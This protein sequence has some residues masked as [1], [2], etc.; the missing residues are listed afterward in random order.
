MASSD[1]AENLGTSAKLRLR[2]GG[3]APIG[4]MLAAVLLTGCGGHSHR[5]A[6]A[7]P[8]GLFDAQNQTTLSCLAHQKQPPGPLYTGG[9][10][11]DTAHILQMMQYYTSNG[12]KP[13]CDK[14]KPSAIDLDWARLY[15]SLGGSPAKVPA[16]LDAP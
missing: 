2:A 5:T 13:F 7:T 1:S 3:R 6:S 16:V 10:H 14:A 11:A 4:A 9:V 8:S 15:V 12:S